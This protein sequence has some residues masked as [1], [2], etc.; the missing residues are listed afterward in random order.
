VSQ[1]ATEPTKRE[2]SLEEIRNIGIAAHI[3]AGKTTTTERILFYTGRIHR[4]GEVDEGAATMDWMPQEQERGIT[5]TS[6][7]TTAVWRDH[8]INIIDTPGHVDFTVEVERSLRVLDGVIALFDAVSG[9]QPQSETVWRQANK[10]N[11]PR[12]AFVNKM[13]RTGANFHRTLHAI[14]ER[15]GARAVA[16]QIPIG[17]ESEFT[18][19][20]DL[21]NMC[22]VNWQD[23]FGSS[24]DIGPI[25]EH[26]LKL[27][28][29][30]HE[31]LLEAAAET[32][33]DLMTKYLETGEL[34]PQEIMQGMRKGTLRYS[35]VPV[36]CGTAARN[37]GVQVLLDAVVDYLPSPKDIKDVRGTDPKTGEIIVHHT[38]DEDPFCALAFKVMSDP[39]VGKLTYFRVYSGVAKRGSSVLNV[40][41]GKNERIGRLLRMHA[42]RREDLPLAR[43]GDIVA[44]VGLNLTTT[45]DT[46]AQS[47]S[48]ILLETIHFPEPVISVAIEPKTKA[49]EEKLALSLERL[50]AEDP[51]FR[52]RTDIDTGQTILSGMGELHLEIICDRLLREFKVEASVGRPQVAYRET[53]SQPATAEGRYIKQSGGRGQYGHVKI[54]LQPLEPGSDFTFEKKIKGGTVP[55]EFIP[56]V[57]AG[58]KEAM[59]SGVIAGFPVVD[60][61]A[62]LLD[63]SYH[64]VDSSELA[65]K[66]AGSIA[67]REA[68]QKA[69]PKLKEPIM[70]VEIVTPE[71]HLGEVLGD[72]N[73]RR[74]HI[75]GMDAS[76]GHTQTIRASVPL[77][78]MFGYSTTLRSLTQGRAT[79][80]ME[81]S[82]YEI[83]PETLA[84]QII[85][86]GH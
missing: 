42:N 28:S 81:P 12:I 61:K 37:K 66:I 49:D 67:F 46:L 34:T 45:G 54:E 19:V 4:M 64:E 84:K 58:I 36:L 76:P 15:L 55:I 75:N 2:Y 5:I 47:D 40:R 60:V 24:M 29:R 1:M 69:K 80:T 43:T 50:E 31:A 18:G 85:E 25:P 33:E 38:T 17:E 51:T 70:A 52:R 23:D 16:L 74:A 44:C 39:H 8:L 59:E 26:L 21:V 79:Y 73:A 11:V 71:E 30:F 57:E 48:P 63:G 35:M 3:D 62:I 22:A 68:A 83:V 13:D 20:V 7:A 56:A 53:I 86:K 32:D 72:L 41:R 14:R 6:A 65:F 77:G 27:S 82:H 9:V 78:E 10:Y